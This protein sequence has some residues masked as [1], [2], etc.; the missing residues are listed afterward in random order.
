MVLKK[1]S[2]TRPYSFILSSPS[3]S[4][5]SPSTTRH[6]PLFLPTFFLPFLAPLKRL[7]GTGERFSSPSGVQGRTANALC[8]NLQPGIGLTCKFRGV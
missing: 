5:F 6:A 8:V 7:G 1:G 2:H 3:P 4:L